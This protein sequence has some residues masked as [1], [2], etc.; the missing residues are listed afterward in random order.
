MLTGGFAYWAASSSAAIASAV[1]RLG[2]ALA[3]AC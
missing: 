1:V 2:A 3:A